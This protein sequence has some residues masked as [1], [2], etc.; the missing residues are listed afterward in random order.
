MRTIV[1]FIGG[2]WDG[3]EATTDEQGTREQRAA[4]AAFVR[5]NGGVLGNRFFMGMSVTAEDDVPSKY[6][7]EVVQRLESDVEVRVVCKHVGYAK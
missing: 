6:E 1:K 3:I 2:P 7:Y 5:T 4:N